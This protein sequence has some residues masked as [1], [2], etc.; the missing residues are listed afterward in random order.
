MS[1]HQSPR[2]AVV[3]TDPE[4]VELDRVRELNTAWHADCICGETHKPLPILA[5]ALIGLRAV[6]PQ[7]FA[8][9]EMLRAPIL[10]TPL[11]PESGFRPRPLCDVDV[12]MIQ[13]KLQHLGL[14]RISKD[15][16]HQAVD[17]RAH[18]RAFHPVRNYL[19][20]VVWDGKPRLET[21][22]SIYFGA[23]VSDYTEKSVLCS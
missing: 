21:F 12:G 23:E 8:Y 11:K 7:V 13:E 3:R 5:N 4:V 16:M 17:V 10:M 6:M 14:K 1:R 20:S 19:N 18:E 15:V 9:D 2:G 22:L